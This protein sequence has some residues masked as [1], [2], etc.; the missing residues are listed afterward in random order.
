MENTVL[1]DSDVL[2]AYKYFLGRGPEGQEAIDWHRGAR[3]LDELRRRFLTSPEFR[4]MYSNLVGVG[5][6]ALPF[7]CPKIEVDVSV[8]PLEAKPLWDRIRAQWEHLGQSEP[9]WSVLT[10]P[11]YLQA[12]L[13]KNQADFYASGKYV[14]DCLQHALARNGINPD[15]LKSC[16]EL[17]CGVG[18]ITAHLAK[19]FESVTAVDI[20]RYHIELARSYLKDQ[21]TDNVSFIHLADLDDL[22]KLEKYDVICTFIVLQ[23]NPPPVI[24]RILA[25]L[26]ESLNSGGIAFFQIPTYIQKYSFRLSEY[27]EN[28]DSRVEMEVHAFPQKDLFE[29]LERCNCSLLEIREDNWL[30]HRSERLSNTLLISKK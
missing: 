27:L 9:H 19:Q 14:V 15:T 11:K 25:R 13:E 30:G 5:I 17:G 1:S 7:D 28:S 6:E 24:A 26:L 12:E 3:D 23:H 16:L 4:K 22:N 10:H 21:A 29:L 20:S 2:L 8:T 18:R